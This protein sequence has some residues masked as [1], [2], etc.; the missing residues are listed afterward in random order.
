M[1]A[2][3]TKRGALFVYNRCIARHDCAIT[4]AIQRDIYVLTGALSVATCVVTIVSSVVVYVVT[5]TVSVA[6]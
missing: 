1:L 5:V 4:F 3:T 6:V 2:V